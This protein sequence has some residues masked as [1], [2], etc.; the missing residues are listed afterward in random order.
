LTARITSHVAVENAISGVISAATRSEV[1]NQTSG[2][3]VSQSIPHRNLKSVRSVSLKKRASNVDE[4]KEVD[5]QKNQKKTL[6]S[7]GNGESSKH[8]KQQAMIKNKSRED[9]FHVDF[10]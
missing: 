8:I 10:I 3:I 6:G 7:S 4:Q 5:E 9:S 2:L 1:C